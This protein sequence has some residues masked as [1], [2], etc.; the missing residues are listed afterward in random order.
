MLIC[1]LCVVPIFF[2]AQTHNIYIA[3]VLIAIAAAAHLG[4]SANVY[5][6][7]SDLFPKVR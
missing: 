4:W 3:T 1:A 5:T 7:A 2:A 6:F